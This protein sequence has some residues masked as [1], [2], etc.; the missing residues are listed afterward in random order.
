MTALRS[1][2][3]AEA[4]AALYFTPG[5]PQPLERFEFLRIFKRVSEFQEEIRSVKAI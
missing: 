5:G 4:A 1:W 3:A 2:L